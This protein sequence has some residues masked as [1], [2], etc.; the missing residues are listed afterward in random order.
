MFQQYGIR[1]RNQD[2]ADVCVNDLAAEV[3]KRLKQINVRGRLLTLK[4]MSRHPDAPVE[5]PKVGHSIVTLG[6]ISGI[7][8]DCSV[9]RA[10]LV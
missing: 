7:D 5:P 2:Q 6:D 3:A 1:F 10:R 8:I 4:V 9:P